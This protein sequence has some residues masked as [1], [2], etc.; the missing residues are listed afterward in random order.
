[1]IRHSP[2]KV[3]EGR[4]FWA[5]NLI[6]PKEKS[7]GWL[8]LDSSRRNLCHHHRFTAMLIVMSSS[9]TI[10]FLLFSSE[11]NIM[12]QKIKSGPHLLSPTLILVKKMSR[13]NITNDILPPSLFIEASLT[14]HG[15]ILVKKYVPT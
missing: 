3:H 10:P 1:M 13:L 15:L 8:I 9:I 5:E 11:Y 4:E 12:I 7:G 6:S 2:C 14:K